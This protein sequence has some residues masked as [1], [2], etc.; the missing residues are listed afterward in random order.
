MPD[1]LLLKVPVEV[2]EGGNWIKTEAA[3]YSSYI[4]FGKKEIQ[5]KQIRDLEYS[6]LDNKEA[7]KILADSEYY[8]NFGKYQKQVFRFLAFN[9]KADKF[10]V[11][12]ISP[13]IRGGVIVSNAKWEKGYLAIT[14]NALWFLSPNKQVRI[15]LEYL[16]SV[17][18]EKRS[19]GGKQRVVLKLT[20]V[21]NNEVIVSYV[22]C[23]ETTLEMLEQ[24]INQLIEQQKPKEKLSEIEE[25]VLTMVYSGVDSSSIESILG[26]ST[27]EL[28]KIYDKLISLGLARLV[29]IRKE[30]E[31][32][33][34]GVS[35][36]DDIMKKA[37]R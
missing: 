33:P 30:V 26:I 37:V 21:D 20:H 24:Y 11:Y 4:Q 28:N 5:F 8:I 18:K 14:E 16:G 6:H 29:K 17:G 15:A 34:R 23:P 7:I 19:V 2:F 13:A 35:F 22:L 36:V 31:L 12:F 25:Q 3:I 32:T 1:K 9:L 27:E 10:A